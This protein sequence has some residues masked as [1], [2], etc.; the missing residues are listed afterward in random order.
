[1]HSGG[2][3]TCKELIRS[4]INNLFVKVGGKKAPDVSVK[5]LRKNNWFPACLSWAKHTHKILFE[6]VLSKYRLQKMI[7]QSQNN[8]E[9]ALE[10]K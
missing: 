3:I 2:Q 1:M 5:A 9:N 8:L 4:R 7:E 10:M 6:W